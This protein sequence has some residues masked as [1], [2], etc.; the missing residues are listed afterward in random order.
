MTFS[1]YSKAQL[2]MRLRCVWPRRREPRLGT[3]RSFL[4]AA[5]QSCATVNGSEANQR[6][7]DQLSGGK[8]AYVYLPDTAAG[9]FTNFNRYYFAQLDKQGTVIDERFNSGGQV[10]DY[11]IEAMQRKLEGYWST[12]TERFK[13]PPRRRSLGRR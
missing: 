6:K 5:K 1:G 10:A 8:L 11:I 2:G 13:R 4:F 12:R 7:V 3:S 9:G